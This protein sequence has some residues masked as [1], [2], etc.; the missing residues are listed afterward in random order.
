M[1][2]IRKSLPDPIFIKAN[3]PDNIKA[4]LEAARAKYFKI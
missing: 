4:R 3:P 2:S 1:K